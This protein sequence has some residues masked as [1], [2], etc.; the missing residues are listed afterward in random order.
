[1][2][3]V[4]KNPPRR[5]LRVFA[6]GLLIGFPVFAMVLWYVSRIRTGM[7]QPSPFTQGMAIGLSAV[8][9]V[10]GLLALASPMLGRKFFIAWMTLTLPI[11]I[12]MSTILL[13]LLY[14]ILLPVFSLIVRRHDPLRKKL[15]GQSYWEDYKP[16][17]PTIERMRRPF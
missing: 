9:I 7:G 6:L 17:E 12:M 3:K 4:N 16:H 5:D 13:T 1:M 15:G 11:G 8:G 14:F 2:F 10:A